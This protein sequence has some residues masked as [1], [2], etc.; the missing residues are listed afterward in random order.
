[1]KGET[2]AR[3]HKATGASLTQKGSYYSPKFLP[4]VGDPPKLHIL[5]EGDTEVVVQNAMKMLT[6]LLNAALAGK[7]Y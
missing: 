1:M 2:L 4:E 3:I 5:V 6:E 7:K